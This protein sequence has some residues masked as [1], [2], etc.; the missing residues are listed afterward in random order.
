[1]ETVFDTS[2]VY[3]SPAKEMICAYVDG[4]W[5]QFLRQDIVAE[6]EAKKNN[7]I[8]DSSCDH[9]YHKHAGIKG[10]LVCGRCG[11]YKPEGA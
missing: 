7:F 11:K 5:A 2:K 4:K 3:M 9:D 8:K 1:M 6:L 10:M